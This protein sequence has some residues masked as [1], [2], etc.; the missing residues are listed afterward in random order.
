MPSRGDRVCDGPSSE[1]D[2]SGFSVLLFYLY[3]DALPT[4][5]GVPDL[6]AARAAHEA[7]C[8]RFGLGGRLRVS[9]EGLNGNLTGQTSLC[10]A[11]C[12]FLRAAADG[13]VPPMPAEIGRTLEAA[14]ASPVEAILRGS[15]ATCDFKLAPCGTE[16]C[17]KGCKVWIANEVAGL[18]GDQAT[19]TPE[20]EAER[21]A[22][23]A[24][25]PGQHLSPKEFHERLAAA[26]GSSGS[27]VLFDAR[28]IYETRVGHFEAPG[29][30][31]IDPGTRNF[32]ELRAYFE[33]EATLER[34]RGKEVFMYC[35]GGVRCERSSALLQKAGVASAVYQLHGGIQRYME[36]YASPSADGVCDDAAPRGFFAGKMHVFDRRGCVAPDGTVGSTE[37]KSDENTSSNTIS[38]CLLCARLWDQ[39]KGKRRCGAC[40]TLVLVCEQCQSAGRDRSAAAALRCELCGRGEEV[41]CADGA[42]GLGPVAKK[43]RAVDSEGIVSLSQTPLLG[44]VLMAGLTFGSAVWIAWGLRRRSTALLTL[45]L[46]A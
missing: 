16:H 32:S 4:S 33:E 36:S 5:L 31:L 24:C 29:V 7:L 26:G 3:Y 37:V 25:P 2:G 14:A 43:T 44:Y 17:F 13:A 19:W 20:L 40:G 27:A 38:T 8:G 21:L 15:M 9:F 30:P 45:A 35:T 39:Y 34:L 46:K 11:Y 23:A 28:N 12:H 18:W 10:E 1:D 22:L 42:D 41:N 6:E